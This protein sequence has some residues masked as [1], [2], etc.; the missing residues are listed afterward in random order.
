MMDLM[1][2]QLLGSFF[3]GLLFAGVAW[4]LWVLWIHAHSPHKI[5]ELKLKYSL[6]KNPF[7][8]FS[9]KFQNIYL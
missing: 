5:V 3:T 9:R 8:S 1:N 2:I 7:V 6:M 4:V